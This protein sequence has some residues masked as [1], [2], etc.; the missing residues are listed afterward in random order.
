MPLSLDRVYYRDTSFI[1]NDGHYQITQ[2]RNINYQKFKKR[3]GL[4][5]FM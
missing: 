4:Q 3:A 2:C 1:L 5:T